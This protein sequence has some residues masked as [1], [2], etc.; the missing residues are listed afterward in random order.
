MVL[1][2]SAGEDME[3]LPLLQH[4]LTVLCPPSAWTWCNGSSFFHG[5]LS[6]TGRASLGSA[7]TAMEGWYRE[8]V[9]CAASG[10]SLPWWPANLSWNPDSI[11]DFSDVK[12][13]CGGTCFLKWGLM[14]TFTGDFFFSK[15]VPKDTTG[16]TCAFQL[17]M[18][19]I[20]CRVKLLKMDPSPSSVRSLL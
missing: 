15:A 13:E 6:D 8:L 10:R 12:L 5:L 7:V 1:T 18:S 17:D 2:A 11:W 19:R 9:W 14:G 20:H 4:L 3:L 16:K